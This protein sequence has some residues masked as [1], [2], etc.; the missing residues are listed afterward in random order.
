MTG[1]VALKIVAEEEAFEA[2]SRTNSKPA[3][4]HTKSEEGPGT[5]QACGKLRSQ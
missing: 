2:I 3:Y 5:D 4:D 1:S